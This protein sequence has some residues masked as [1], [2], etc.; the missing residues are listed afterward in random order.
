MP[1]PEEVPPPPPAMQVIE[2]L[3]ISSDETCERMRERIEEHPGWADN[4]L[5]EPP[6]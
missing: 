6:D 3:E 5:A 1:H 2:K 4:I